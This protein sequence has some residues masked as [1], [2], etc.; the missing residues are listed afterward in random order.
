MKGLKMGEG[1]KKVDLVHLSPKLGA[2]GFVGTPSHGG[3]RCTNR[4]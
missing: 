3:M 1:K 2:C 4:G